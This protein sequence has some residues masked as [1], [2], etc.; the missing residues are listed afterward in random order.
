MKMW[1][2]GEAL[3]LVRSIEP[4]V[5]VVGWHVALGG[6]VLLRGESTHDLDLIFIPHST[7]KM[8]IDNLRMAFVGL[9]WRRMHTAA[10]MLSSWQR[11]GSTDRKFVEVWCTPEGRRVDVILP[12][13]LQ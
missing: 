2:L 7:A 3:A 13:V 11:K 5:A 9:S 12:S 4:V 8:V 1:T 6:G 10:M